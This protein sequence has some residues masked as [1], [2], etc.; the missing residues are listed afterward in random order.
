MKIIPGQFDD[1]QVQALLRLHLAG[2]HASSPPGSVFALDL[3]GLQKPDISF[4]TAWR[5]GKLLGMGAL[6]AL[7]AETG[8]IKSMR[9]DPAALRSG[10]GAAILEHLIELARR[11]NYRRLSLETGSGP[12]FEA[13]LALYR[14]R[15][16]VNGEAFGGY[17]ASAFNQFLHLDL[18]RGS[19]NKRQAS[20]RASSVEHLGDANDLNASD[21]ITL[22]RASRYRRRIAMVSDGGREFLL[23]LPVA[24]HLADGDALVLDTGERIRV[25]AAVEPLLEIHTADPADLARIAWHIGNRHTPAEVTAHAIYIQPDHVLEEMVVGLGAHVHHVERPFEPEGGAYGHKGALEH[26]HH[27]GGHHHH[28][29]Q[30]HTHEHGAHTHTHDH[31]QR[32]EGAGRKPSVWRPE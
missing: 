2:M 31:G 21:T 22:D 3:S 24:T 12:A 7:D 11:R 27:H 18:S 15:G 14:K 17:T 10:V 29:G 9:T 26:G 19:D 5:D 6:K 30:S 4:F 23:D 32:Y 20:A 1:P 28:H 16:F 8:E 25:R 13:A